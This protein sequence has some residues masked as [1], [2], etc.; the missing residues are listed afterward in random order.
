VSEERDPAAGHR[1]VGLR[2]LTVGVLFLFSMAAVGLFFAA[3]RFADDQENRLLAGR[4]AELGQLLSGAVI[5][6]LQGSLISLAGAAQSPTPGDFDRAAAGL[7]TSPT[8][9]AVALIQQRGPDWVVRSAAGTALKPGEVISGPRLDLVR[10][11]GSKPRTD[12]FPVASGGSRLGFVLG[13]P[14]APAG[15]VVYEEYAV[16]PARPAAIAQSAPFHELNVA[17][18]VGATPDPAKLILA[19]TRTVP[20]RGRTASSKIAAG[21]SSWLVVA[22]AHQPLSGTLA[23]NVRWILLAA[24]LLIGAAMAAVVEAVARRRDYAMG[25]VADRTGELEDSLARL[26]HTQEALLSSERLAALGQMAATVGHE[27]RNPLGVLTNSLYLIRSAVAASA[28]ERLTRQLDTA[29]REIAAATL[30]VSDLLEFSR[31]RASNLAPV[32]VGELLSEAASVAPPGAGI[33]LERADEPG[34]PPVVADRDQ[35]RQV[36]LNLLM[37]AY[38]A[39]PE[40]GGVSMA[41]RVADAG[42]E[43]VVT[44]TG[45]GMDAATC[46]QV[47]EPFFS[48][49]IKGTGL[50]LA[51]SKRIVESHGGTLRL[52]SQLGEGCTAVVWIPLQPVAVVAP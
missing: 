21:D 35:L 2:R 34:L 47:F 17:L 23:V 16:D 50:G 19:T 18:Y 22:N 45:T 24:V 43:I 4:T 12:V 5:G 1:R 51:V 3:G 30:I 42:V 49:K 52:Q 48:K 7:V 36:V 41:A 26:E 44:D 10:T 39:M 46:Q 37:N 29:E 38:E 14:A 27:L 11:A 28:D 15:T 31:P 33:S 6:T 25:L 9:A 32:D 13:A 8:V 20:L 40:G